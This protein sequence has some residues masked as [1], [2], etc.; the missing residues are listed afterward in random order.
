[1]LRSGC[2]RVE[3]CFFE[4]FRH[5]LRPRTVAFL[6]SA[7]RFL[8]E[9]IEKNH[10]AIQVGWTRPIDALTTAAN[11]SRF[12]GFYAAL[13]PVQGAL[14]ALRVRPE[15]RPLLGSRWLQ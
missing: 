10:R 1:V 8:D 2:L 9:L 15:P 7:L 11:P 12:E 4:G 14:P 13:K 3:A 6:R 5:G